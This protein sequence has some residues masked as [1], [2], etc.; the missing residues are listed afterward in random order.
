V[1]PCA[2]CGTTDARPFHPGLLRCAAC[3]HAWA[4]LEL[5]PERIA[6][7]YGPG[8][9]HGEEY[10]DYP[11]DRAALQK[12]FRRRLAELEPCLDPARH[13]RLLEVGCAYGFFLD[14]ARGR[15]ESVSG[16]D[17][18]AEAV[19]HARESLSL[20]AVQGDLLAHDFGGRSFDVVCLWDT[21][22][23]LARP[24]LAVA[25]IH[26]LTAPGALLALTTGDIGSLLARLRGRRW[27]LIHPPT[28]LHYFTRGSLRRLL[29]RHGFEVI[30]DRTCGFHRGVLSAVH[31]LLGRGP[32]AARPLALLERLG[33]G[34]LS[35]YLDVG[36]IRRVV[37][38]RL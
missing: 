13:R 33:L 38:R 25:R 28:H 26:D 15:F 9:F 11:A 5:P 37:A 2:A 32:R 24:D 27:R 36:D 29:E 19:R 10:R 3:G 23:H 34:R 21:I 7:L 35:F 30:D 12:S 16:I 22:E 31:G 14:L 4:D 20:D 8:Y 6:A 18:S 17:V 1:T